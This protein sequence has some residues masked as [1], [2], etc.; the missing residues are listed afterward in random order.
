[1]K[2]NMINQSK[3]LL[4]IAAATLGLSQVG[5]VSM[6]NAFTGLSSTQQQE[7]SLVKTGDLIVVQ[8]A[9]ARRPLISKL[10]RDQWVS[11]RR[12]ATKSH[13]RAYAALAAGE[14]EVAIKEAHTYLRATPKDKVA[15]TILSSA[16]TMQKNYQLAGHYARSIEK[17]HGVSAASRNILGISTLM[18]SGNNITDLL[19][20]RSLFAESFELAPGE[21]AAALNLGQLQLELGHSDA[22]AETFAA[23]EARCGKCKPAVLGYGIALSR[24]GKY[25]RAAKQ[26]DILLERNDQDRDALYRMALLQKNG[27]N[28]NDLAI[29]YLQD[30]IAASPS[31]DSL[32]RR[33]R[34]LIDRL[35]DSKQKPLIVAQTD[36]EPNS[37]NSNPTVIDSQDEGDAH[38]LV[39]SDI[40]DATLD[41]ALDMD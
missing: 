34:S 19:R 38:E 17:Y 23:A 40:F 25:D 13:V 28:E 2:R 27:F 41:E 6:R 29:N 15:L 21:I 39:T 20:A 5:C 31:D 30:L 16:L 18:Q 26:F 22:A 32:Q 10:E 1:M 3:S 8:Q 14:W 24:I 4:I 33:A 37:Q 7:D 35:R 9:G 11:I 12:E 36:V